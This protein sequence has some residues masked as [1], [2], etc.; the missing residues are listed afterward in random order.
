MSD[1][2]ISELMDLLQHE[3]SKSKQSTSKSSPRKSKVQMIVDFFEKR[4][5]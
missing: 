1:E 5:G 3:A 2:D 4:K